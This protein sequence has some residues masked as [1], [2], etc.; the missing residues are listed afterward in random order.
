MHVRATSVIAKVSIQDLF[1]CGLEVS[2]EHL[3]ELRITFNLC[4]FLLLVGLH[5]LRIH[6]GN[7]ELNT[8]GPIIVYHISERIFPEFFRHC[9]WM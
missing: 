5:E 9:L 1:P 4:I 3:G 7:K 8:D 6:E 2:M